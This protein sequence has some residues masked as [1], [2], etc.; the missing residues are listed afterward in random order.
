MAP[1]NIQKIDAT[2]F[3]PYISQMGALYEQLRQVKN[4]EDEAQARRRSESDNHFKG[5]EDYRKASG[6]PQSTRKGSIA[7]IPSATITTE[8]LSPRRRG[9]SLGCSGPHTPP[10]STVPD[11]YF[12]ED[13][14]LENPRTFDVVSEQS[15]VM[16]P[17]SATE[18]TSNRNA[19]APIKALATNAIL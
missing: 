9:S 2:E 5:Y 13:F 16:P 8:H 18:K 15:D 1:T 10:L 4:G 6:Q 3:K 12:G 19:P 7:S 14:H 17:T 11:V